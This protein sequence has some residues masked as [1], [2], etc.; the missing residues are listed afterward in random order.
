MLKV[1]YKQGWAETEYVNV[2]HILNTTWKYLY[3]VRK[4][5]F[6][7]AALRI[8]VYVLC[9]FFGQFL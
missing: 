6:Q 5:C 3:T 8:P 1:L 9:M 4:K 7:K 2:L